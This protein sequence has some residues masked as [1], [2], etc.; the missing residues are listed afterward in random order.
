MAVFTDEN[1]KSFG[2]WMVTFL[3]DSKL[4]QLH[5]YERLSNLFYHIQG[6]LLCSPNK[7]SWS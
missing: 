5:L 6:N 7:I 2:E 3:E 4:H 1:G